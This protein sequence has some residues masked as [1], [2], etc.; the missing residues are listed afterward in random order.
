MADPDKIVPTNAGVTISSTS[1]KEVPFIYFDGVTCFGKNG[2]I[3]QIELAANTLM[4]AAPAV[5]IDVV[6]VVHLRCSALAAAALRESIDKALEMVQQGPDQPQAI[7][8]L[9]N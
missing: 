6:Q 8:T 7:P 9:K 3:I 1:A 5:R 2:D 4:P